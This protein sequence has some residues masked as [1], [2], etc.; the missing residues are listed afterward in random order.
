M[1]KVIGEISGQS[2]DK[3]FKLPGIKIEDECPECKK[4]LH[5]DSDNEGHYLS[6]PILGDKASVDFHFY[7]GDCNKE[8]NVKG[9]LGIT[10]KL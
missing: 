7:C 3:R 10:I 9:T 6:Y 4:I 8:W 2:E 1:A 5:W